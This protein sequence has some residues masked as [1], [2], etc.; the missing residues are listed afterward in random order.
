MKN[1]YLTIEIDGQ[2]NIGFINAG[3]EMKLLYIIFI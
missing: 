3:V 2:E 1:E